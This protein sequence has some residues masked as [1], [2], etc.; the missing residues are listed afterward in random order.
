MISTVIFSVAALGGFVLSC[1]AAYLNKNWG[2]P[3][4]HSPQWITAG[5]YK[6]LKHPMYVGNWLAIAGC[7]GLAAGWWNVL[8]VGECTFL[9]LYEWILR[10]NKHTAGRRRHGGLDDAA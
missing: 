9:L 1:W 6:Y 2:G 3:D 8:A 7:A 10:E 4:S 5:P